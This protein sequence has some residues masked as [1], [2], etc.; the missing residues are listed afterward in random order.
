MRRRLPAYGL[1][2]FAIERVILWAGTDDFT[3]MPA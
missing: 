2:A 3:R 1:A